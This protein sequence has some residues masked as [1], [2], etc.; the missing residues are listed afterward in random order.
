MRPHHLRNYLRPWTPEHDREL[1]RLV[2][3]GL[4]A[5]E[6]AAVVGRTRD[7]VYAHGNAIGITFGRGNRPDIDKRAF[8]CALLAKGLTLRKIAEVRGVSPA[9]VNDVV[10]RMVKSGAVVRTGPKR[11][12]PGYQPQ[13]VRFRPAHVDARATPSNDR[14]PAA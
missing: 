6:I 7:G 1:R 4:N 13:K 3:E 11:G 14:Q 12:E 10:W 5:K 8:T 9:T 2:G